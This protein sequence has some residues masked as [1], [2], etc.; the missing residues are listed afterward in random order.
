MLRWETGF[1]ILTQLSINWTINYCTSHFV[2]ACTKNWEWLLAST[3]VCE[4]WKEMPSQENVLDPVSNIIWMFYSG[5]AWSG[6]VTLGT[7]STMWVRQLIFSIPPTL[8]PSTDLDMWLAIWTSSNGA[9]WGEVCL[10]LKQTR[11]DFHN[12]NSELVLNINRKFSLSG[13]AVT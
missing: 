7:I 10:C 8:C 11:T 13:F 9:T 3:Q 6:W 2:S 12:P 4:R 1:C 5:F